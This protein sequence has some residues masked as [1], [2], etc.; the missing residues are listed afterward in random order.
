MLR[1]LLHWLL[2]FCAIPP[3]CAAEGELF[4]KCRHPRNKR[5][6]CGTCHHYAWRKDGL[7]RP[8]ELVAR[9][10]HMR[11]DSGQPAQQAIRS[12]RPG[13]VA[14]VAP[15]AAA[16]SREEAAAAVATGGGGTVP[17]VG[18]QLER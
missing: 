4:H 17:G 7:M 13:T 16:A 1:L 9:D 11:D 6:L 18:G 5:P 10:P 12:G 3:N 2:T 8:W 14:A 15:S